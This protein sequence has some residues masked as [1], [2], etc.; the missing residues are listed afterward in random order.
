MMMMISNS[1]NGDYVFSNDIGDYDVEMM[2]NNVLSVGIV[3]D[4]DHDD[5][6]YE[7]NT[8]IAL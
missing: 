5:R 2:M 3:S 7:D 8:L 1:I 6:Y 4:D